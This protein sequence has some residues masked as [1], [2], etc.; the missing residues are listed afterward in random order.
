MSAFLHIRYGGN[1]NYWRR[2][3]PETVDR[4][5][6]LTLLEATVRAPTDMHEEP[7]AVFTVWNMQVLKQLSDR[8]A[9]RFAEEMRQRNTSKLHRS[10]EHFAEADFDIF[11]EQAPSS[12]FAQ[13][14]WGHSRLPIAGSPRKT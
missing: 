1:S 3:E 10:F 11:H 9:R 14:L 4:N 7:W 5:T 6:V 12:S 13:N 8:T 2:Y